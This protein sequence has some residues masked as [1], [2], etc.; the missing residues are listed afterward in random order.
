MME[1]FSS[2][3]HRAPVGTLQSFMGMVDEHLW[4]RSLFYSR[5]SCV[6][7][8]FPPRQSSPVLIAFV[9]F[10]P[11]EQ[12]KAKRTVLQRDVASGPLAT[13]TLYDSSSV[14]RLIVE[15]QSIV[16]ACVRR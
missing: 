10:R 1:A 9:S 4:S 13:S 11:V 5:R 2:P 3:A 16:N 6:L 12:P 8:V 15:G 14:E 7:R